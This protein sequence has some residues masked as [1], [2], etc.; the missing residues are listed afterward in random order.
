MLCLSLVCRL[1]T[2]TTCLTGLVGHRSTL[3]VKGRMATPSLVFLFAWCATARHHLEKESRGHQY[4]YIIY[5][6]VNVETRVR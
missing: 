2:P 3:C 4:I 6:F 1:V 5:I